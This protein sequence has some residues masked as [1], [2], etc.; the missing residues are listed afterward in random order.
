MFEILKKQLYSRV[1]GVKYLKSLEQYGLSI[2]S[3]ENHNTYWFW[4]LRKRRFWSFFLT[5]KRERSL[6]CDTFRLR[7]R[8]LCVHRADFESFI[9]LRQQMPIEQLFLF[10]SAHWNI[11]LPPF[12]CAFPGI[13]RRCCL[14]IRVTELVTT[15]F[16]ITHHL[17]FVYVCAVWASIRE[18]PIRRKIDLEF[19][20]T[21]CSIYTESTTIKIIQ[22]DV[23]VDARRRRH[24][25]MRI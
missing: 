6:N 18:L 5:W 4:R 8:L 20:W 25:H 12:A 16:S 2:L 3:Y 11:F 13:R 19:N 21:L 23:G 7:T 9:F 10:S 1:S 17:Q 15:L 22:I 14:C 24:T